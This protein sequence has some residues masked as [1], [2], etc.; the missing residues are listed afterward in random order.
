[1][2]EDYNCYVNN[3]TYIYWG[4]AECNVESKGGQRAT[5][6]KNRERSKSDSVV[7]ERDWETGGRD[8]DTNGVGEITSC[9]GNVYR[10]E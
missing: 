2:T 10:K 6:I 9:C 1:M 3:A 4:R 5:V 8:G 7:E